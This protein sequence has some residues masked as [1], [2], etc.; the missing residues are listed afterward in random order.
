MEKRGRETTDDKRD[1]PC[2]DSGDDEEEQPRF[3]ILEFGRFFVHRCN[4]LTR[5]G[6]NYSAIKGGII[7]SNPVAH[8][9][10]IGEKRNYRHGS[11]IRVFPGG[12]VGAN[13]GTEAF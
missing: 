4:R 1:E 8:L 13:R 2:R 6:P 10:G 7:P 3:E 5:S 9:E 11:L 12:R